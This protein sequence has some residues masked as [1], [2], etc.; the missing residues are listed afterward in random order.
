[1]RIDL[2]LV[3]EGFFESRSKAQV[4]IKEGV[5]YINDKLILKSSYEVLDSDICKVISNPIKYVSRGGYKLEGAIEKFNLDFKDK[6]V[7]D[8]GSSTGGF[9]DCALQHGAKEVYAVDVGSAQLHE[10]L[11]ENKKVKSIENCNILYVDLN[12]TFDFLVMDVSFTSIYNMIPALKKYLNK[13]NM[14]VCLIKPQFE[15]G[16]MV[17][18]GVIKD[19]KLHLSILNKVDSYLKEEGLYINKIAPSPIKGGSGNIEFISLISIQNEG[20]HL[21]FKKCVEEAWEAYNA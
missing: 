20:V 16:K 17:N 7:L 4:A 3:K 8:I 6:V 11:R 14:L 5:V 15:A 13:N 2:Y 9:T 18:K 19:R 10:S 12:V 1:M 21:D